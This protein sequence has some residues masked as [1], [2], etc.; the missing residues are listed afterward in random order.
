MIEVRNARVSGFTGQ[1]TLPEKGLFAEDDV[2]CLR[3]AVWVA[4][5]YLA[6]CHNCVERYHWTAKTS[7]KRCTCRHERPSQSRLMVFVLLEQ[8]RINLTGEN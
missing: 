7:Q 1:N 5:K 2:L 3:A 8:I 6:N 4:G